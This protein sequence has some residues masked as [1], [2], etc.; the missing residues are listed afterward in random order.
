VTTWIFE[1]VVSGD[2]IEIVLDVEA[3]HRGDLERTGAIAYYR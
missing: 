1:G 3:I 2:E